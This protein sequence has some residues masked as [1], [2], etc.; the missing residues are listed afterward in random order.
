MNFPR[1]MIGMP[2]G[3]GHT[4]WLTT[5][6]LINTLR[7]CDKAGVK[8]KLEGPIGCSVVPWARSLIV[9]E[10]LKSD[11][12]HL[13]W[14]DSDIA[15]AP[16]DFFRL[17][18]FAGVLEIVGA[19]YPLKKEPVDFLVNHLKPGTTEYEVNGLGCVK[20]AS[21]GIGFTI[22]QRKVIEK[23]AANTPYV[24]DR[25]NGTRYRDIFRIDRTQRAEAEEPGPRGEDIA[26]FDDARAAGF[27]VWLDP[28]IQI[29]HVGTKVYRGSP[30]DALGLTAFA[31][32]TP[33]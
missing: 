33:A 31:Q 18:G 4:P 20:I 7:A 22:F 21:M 3:S 14:I 27:D 28:S 11:F 6:S 26:F 1:V 13:F 8:V 9:E 23:I 24:R 16:D 15:W 25:M 30:I 32:E 12:T 29:G 2:V 5:T 19:T 10:F 17:V